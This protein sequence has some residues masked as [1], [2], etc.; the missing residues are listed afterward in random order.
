L[1]DERNNIEKLTLAALSHL[2]TA[3]LYV[4]DLT[5]DCGTT[6]PDQ[7][8]PHLACKSKLMPFFVHALELA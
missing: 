7:V 5:G 1:T 4:H 3:V 8:N 2:P 6:V